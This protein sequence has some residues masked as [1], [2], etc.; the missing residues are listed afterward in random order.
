MQW[1]G[2]VREEVLIRGD[3]SPCELGPDAMGELAG[4]SDELRPRERFRLENETTLAKL[5]S[6]S[7]VEGG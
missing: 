4:L 6:S 5:T 2:R 3:P 1:D 7:S